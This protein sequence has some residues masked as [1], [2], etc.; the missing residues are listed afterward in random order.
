VTRSKASASAIAHSTEFEKE[1]QNKI[2][3]NSFVNLGE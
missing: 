3:Q 1:Q 2:I